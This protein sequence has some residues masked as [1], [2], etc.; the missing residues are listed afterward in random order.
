MA[1]SCDQRGPGVSGNPLDVAVAQFGAA[2]IGARGRSEKQRAARGTTGEQN[3]KIHAGNISRRG[4]EMLPQERML[5]D[6]RCPGS[7]PWC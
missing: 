3:A 1:A 7:C 6:K 2:H 5:K 4:A